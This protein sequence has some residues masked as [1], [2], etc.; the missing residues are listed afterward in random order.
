M[1]LATPTRHRC[2]QHPEMGVHTEARAP[3]A[4]Q[5]CHITYERDVGKEDGQWRRRGVGGWLAAF[6]C[7]QPLRPNKHQGEGGGRGLLRC[8]HL[9][10]PRAP[11]QSCHIVCGQARERGNGAGAVGG[12]GAFGLPLACSGVWASS[13]HRK[14]GRGVPQVRC[15]PPRSQ[16]RPQRCFHCAVPWTTDAGWMHPGGA[17]A[18]MPLEGLLMLAPAST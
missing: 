2:P 11:A 12:G 13:T 17:L 15:R 3:N 9:P 10:P 1:A 14:N 8:R 16:A 6:E 7:H 4:G 18:S 5:G